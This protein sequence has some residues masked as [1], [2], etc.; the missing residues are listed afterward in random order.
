MIK[1]S[2]RRKKIKFMI[3]LIKYKAGV[4]IAYLYKVYI[5]TAFR[6]GIDKMALLEEGWSCKELRERRLRKVEEI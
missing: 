2:M 3:E 5:Y 6:L 1:E 4:I